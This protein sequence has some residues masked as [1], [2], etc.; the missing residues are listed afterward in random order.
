MRHWK[1]LGDL[2]QQLS[3]LAKS[4]PDLL[5]KYGLGI[6]IIRLFSNALYR[7]FQLCPSAGT[8]APPHCL[9]HP[10]SP[11]SSRFDC[12]IF[13][14]MQHGSPIC[15]QRCCHIGPSLLHDLHHLSAHPCLPA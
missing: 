5:S 1:Q 4:S 10:S 9:Q 6:R 11:V 7:F 14:P 3:I 8:A 2:P 12:G 13:G 15:G